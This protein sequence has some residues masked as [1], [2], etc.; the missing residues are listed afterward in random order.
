MRLS[1]CS[2]ISTTDGNNWCWLQQHRNGVIYTG[3]C[4]ENLNQQCVDVVNPDG[5][6]EKRYNVEAG[7]HC[8]WAVGG[9]WLSSPSLSTVSITIDQ[10]TGREAV[11][12]EASNKNY[13]SRGCCIRQMNCLS[14]YPNSLCMADD[15]DGKQECRKGGGWLEVFNM[16]VFHFIS[17]FFEA[18]TH[19][20]LAVIARAGWD[21]AWQWGKN[22][23]LRYKKHQFFIMTMEL[24]KERLSDCWNNRLRR[25]FLTV[26]L[27]TSRIYW[28]YC[29][30]DHSLLIWI[31][32]SSLAFA[33]CKYARL[34]NCLINKSINTISL[35]NLVFVPQSESTILSTQRKKQTHATHP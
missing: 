21:A 17:R 25:T 6:T 8:D 15:D 19:V 2:Y 33:E 11:E 13:A 23:I 24:T 9:A 5:T 20:I 18:L 12:Q 30:S 35:S 1:R 3:I 10:I 4:N 7:T 29:G 16:L 14:P 26:W 28:S 32:L 31:H 22:T 27:S 34:V